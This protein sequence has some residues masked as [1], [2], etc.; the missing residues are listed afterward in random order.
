MLQAVFELINATFN[1]NK[2]N[3]TSIISKHIALSVMGADT[4]A[5]VQEFDITSTIFVTFNKIFDSVV[6]LALCTTSKA[7]LVCVSE[8]SMINENFLSVS[9]YL[10]L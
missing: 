9:L 4:F 1:A 2:L 3:Y 6:K 8:R 10:L 5:V 7:L